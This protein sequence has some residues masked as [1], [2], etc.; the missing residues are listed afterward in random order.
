M[1]KEQSLD[2]VRDHPH[3][4]LGVGG[5]MEKEQTLLEVV[6]VSPEGEGGGGEGEGRD[7]VGGF[8]HKSLW[9]RRGRA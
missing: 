5:H 4:S 3:K 2:S 9:K 7:S 1:E 6:H 8:P